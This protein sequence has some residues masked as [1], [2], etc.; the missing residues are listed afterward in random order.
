MTFP[1]RHCAVD[2]YLL[3]Q[4]AFLNALCL[5]S[6]Y[7]PRHRSSRVFRCNADEPLIYPFGCDEC[8][9]LLNERMELSVGWHVEDVAQIL[10]QEH[11]LWIHALPKL[12]KAWQVGICL[13][14][15]SVCDVVQLAPVWAHHHARRTKVVLQL[16][17]KATERLRLLVH[18]YR[19]GHARPIPR[20]RLTT[21]MSIVRADIDKH[22]PARCPVCPWA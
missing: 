6:S 12:K 9:T 13:R 2:H 1:S 22:V 19:N 16:S 4:S 7:L 8:F 21:T 11:S 3:S 10:V 17:N 18:H 5:Q 15:L 14:Q 20:R